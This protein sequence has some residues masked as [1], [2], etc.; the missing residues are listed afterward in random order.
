MQSSNYTTTLNGVVSAVISVDEAR[1]IIL[2]KIERLSGE[3]VPIMDALGRVL[4]EDVYA[5]ADIPPFNNSAMDG[6][7]V[8][9]ADT[10]GAC[11]F[12]GIELHVLGDVAAGYV[13]TS[14]IGA[15]EAIRIMTG[16]QMPEGADAVVMVEYTEK[17]NGGVLIK[18]EVQAN[19][20]VR[21]AGEDIKAGE[22][23]VHRGKKL[24]P[25]D[26]GVLASVG[27]AIVQVVRRPVVAII[28][29]GDELVDLGEPLVPG[30][31]RNSN[32]YG[33][34]AQVIEAGGIPLMLGIARDTREALMAKVEE[35]TSADMIITTG[36]V[37]VGDYDFVKDIL[38]VAGEMVFWKVAM[39]PGK[40]LAFGIIKGKPVIGLPGYPT[41]S[42]ISFDQFARPAMLKMSGRTDFMRMRIEA[43][44]ED[45]VKN[46]SGRRNMIRVIVRRDDG[47][48]KARL[49]GMQKSGNIKPLSLAN[50]V[51]VV[52]EAVRQVNPGDTVTVELF[53]PITE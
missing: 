6:Y 46:K 32:G 36:G 39:K 3:E 11:P 14:A 48:F 51:M 37:S 27:K 20:N 19:E 38:D 22:I 12:N 1:E 29:T 52:P 17:T 45:M 31:I 23:A 33:I 40:P 50:G 43:I 5:E 7:A 53:E 13:P 18:D 44:A 25:G 47:V 34:A 4:D 21:F 41:S 24:T 9:A 2:S 30:K 16:A 15:G 49:S 10:A 28:T 8:Q 26:I 35:G 42:M